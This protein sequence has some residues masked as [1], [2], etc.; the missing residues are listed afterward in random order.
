MLYGSTVLAC[1]CDY[2]K[3]PGWDA[4]VV[5][6]LPLEPEPVPVPRRVQGLLWRST[7]PAPPPWWRPQWPTRPCPMGSWRRRRWRAC[8]CRRHPHPPR[9]CGRRA[10]FRRRAAARC[11][12][13]QGAARGTSALS[14]HSSWCAGWAQLLSG[15]NCKGVQRVAGA[16]RGSGCGSSDAH[17]SSHYIHICLPACLQVLDAA[18]DGYVRGEA[19]LVMLLSAAPAPPAGRGGG[20][21][22]TAAAV[23]LA[24]AAVNQDGRSSS[25]TAPNGPAQQAVIRAALAEAGVSGSQLSWLSMHGTG[26]AEAGQGRQE[27]LMYLAYAPT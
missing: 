21:A 16:G 9:M 19:L 2:A 23:V 22:P 24:G 15:R 25:L 11:A 5:L 20:H 14:M 4:V 8:T 26:E 12:G 13:V 10:C 27:I 17:R 3:G 6:T 7:L 18:A 1:I